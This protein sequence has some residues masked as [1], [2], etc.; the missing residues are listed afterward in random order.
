ML[1]ISWNDD[2]THFA[3]TNV[4]GPVF[5]HPADLYFLNISNLQGYTMEN[6][7]DPEETDAFKRMFDITDTTINP[8]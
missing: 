5:A 1:F 4:A 3:L 8:D 7:L 2:C 6:R